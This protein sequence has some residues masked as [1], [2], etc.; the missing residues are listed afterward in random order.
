MTNAV[1]GEE[2]LAIATADISVTMQ[3]VPRRSV[4]VAANS[5]E[6]HNES[7]KEQP[8]TISGHRVDIELEGSLDYD[9]E[10]VNAAKTSFELPFTALP[11]DDDVEVLATKFATNIYDD[12]ETAAGTIGLA[13]SQSGVELDV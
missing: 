11:D 2:A 1:P 9:Q 8:G 4:A 5:S 12:T 13:L 10:S 7:N 3:K 6:M